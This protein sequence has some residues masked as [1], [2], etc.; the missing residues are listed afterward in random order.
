MPE[1]VILKNS[2]LE[3]IIPRNKNSFRL[4][5]GHSVNLF[6]LRQKMKKKMNNKEFSTFYHLFWWKI[7]KEKTRLVE[8]T[9]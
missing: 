8:P 9:L 4:P 7:E 2:N 3:N 5:N 6:P 1:K